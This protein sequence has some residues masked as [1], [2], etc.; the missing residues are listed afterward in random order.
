MKESRNLL[1]NHIPGNLTDKNQGGQNKS[2]ISSLKAILST[3]I[4]EHRPRKSP[5][6]TVHQLK[7]IQMLK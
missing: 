4:F 5:T 2:N 1:Q 7:I 6:F 3:L